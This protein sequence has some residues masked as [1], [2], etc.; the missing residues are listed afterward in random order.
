MGQ[1][2]KYY[3]YKQQ[4]RVSGTST[5]YDV[6]PTV[7]SIDGNGTMLVQ[8]AEADA[9]ECGYVPPVEPIYRWVR[10]DISIYWVCDGNN[11]YYKEQK[12]V[13]Y[14]SGTTW[15]KLEEYRIGDL[16]QESSLDCGGGTVIDKWVDGYMCDDCVQ[17]ALVNERNGAAI[18]VECSSSTTINPSDITNRTSISA[19]TIG[20]CITSIGNGAYSGCTSLQSVRIPSTVTSIGDN[21]FRGCSVL[22]DASIPDSVTSIG[23]GAFSGCTQIT[24]INLPNGITS[25]GASA[26]TSCL[27]F[28]TLNIPQTLTSIPNACFYN[29]DGMSDITLPSTVTSI[30]DSAFRNCDGLQVLQINATTPPT[31]GTNALA[32]TNAN[33]KILVPPSAVDTYKAASGWSTYANKIQAITT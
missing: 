21:A 25:I 14:N 3:L 5:W 2:D 6:V 24:Y 1:F 33:L 20:K 22:L 19:S 28:A 23:S 26:F 7:Y 8:I 12:E 9:E 13:S 16:Y 15:Q 10:M 17:Y 32:N 18:T 31:L 29:C 11:K 30:G 27:N 4:R